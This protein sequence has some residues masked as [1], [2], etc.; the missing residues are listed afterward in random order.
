MSLLFQFRRGFFSTK[1][2]GSKAR[3]FYDAR[4]IILKVK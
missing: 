4:S 3:Y 1:Y 2:D